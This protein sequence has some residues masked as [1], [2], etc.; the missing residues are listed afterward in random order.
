VS[1][2]SAPAA[3]ADLTEPDRRSL[4]GGRGPL[5]AVYLGTLVLIGLSWLAAL[6]LDK[7]LSDFT[8][9]PV[10]VFGGAPLYLGL[11]S[12]VGI[13][14]WAGTAAACF[15]AAETLRRLRHPDAELLLA[16]GALSAVLAADDIFLFHERS[17]RLGIPQASVAAVYA[18][19]LGLFVFRYRE[20]LR[21]TDWK[22][23]VA[24]A[25][26]FGASAF[27]DW[28]AEETGAGLRYDALEDS[29][30]LVGVVT[31]AAYFCGLAIQS[32]SRAA[33]PGPATSS[34][35]T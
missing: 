4:L 20:S 12:N 31:W 17:G 11:L 18:L 16:A 2:P 35:G 6:A 21:R 5:A 22:L 13:L 28:F 27:L 33:A 24:A 32:L 3:P 19:L 30:K 26:L 10:Q 9:D 29:I 23:L 1:Q 8:R 15:V 14:L 34:P 25:A 7:P